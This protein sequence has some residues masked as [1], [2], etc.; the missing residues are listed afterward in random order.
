MI[1]IIIVLGIF[2][3]DYNLKSYTNSHRIQGTEDQYFGGRLILRNCHNG[4]GG[5]GLFKK[6]PKLGTEISAVVLICVAWEF[7]KTFFTKGFALMKLGLSLV[8]GAGASNFYDRITKGYVTDY[9]SLGVKNK[10]VR[11]TVFN[12]SGMFIFAGAV[13]YVI[14]YLTS[15]AG[16]KK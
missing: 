8:L 2:L 15:K 5:F 13:I 11:N 9:F 10:K 12:L 4:E 7:V 1:F 16:N 14:G 6:N 3:L